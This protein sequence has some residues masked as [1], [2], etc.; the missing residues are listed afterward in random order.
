MRLNLSDLILSYH[1]HLPIL[2]PPQEPIDIFTGIT[3]EQARR[4]A[5]NLKFEGPLLDEVGELWQA[6]SGILPSQVTFHS[7]KWE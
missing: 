1:H 7:L 3:D 6:C 2:T 5:G 4:M